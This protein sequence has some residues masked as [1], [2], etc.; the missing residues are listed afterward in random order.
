MRRVLIVANQTAVDDQLLDVVQ[1]LTANG[2]C[3][4]EII[5]PVTPLTEQEASLRHSEHLAGPVGESGAVTVARQRL[6][7]AQ[8]TLAALG[9]QAEGDIGHPNPV[10]AVAAVM[11]VN[12]ADL[13][14][15]ATLPRRLSRWMSSDVPGRLRRKHGVDVLHVETASRARRHAAGRG[16]VG[17]SRHA[18]HR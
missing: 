15:V 1:S 2:P 11:A 18:S 4:F 12:P 14:V 10:K 8:T 3:S 17:V 5:I 16:V 9:I 7:A 13:I 6:H